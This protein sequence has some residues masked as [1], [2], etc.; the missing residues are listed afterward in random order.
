MAVKER[1]RNSG[2]SM[3]KMVRDPH[4]TRFS[5]LGLQSR[6]AELRCSHL[7]LSANFFLMRLHA[8]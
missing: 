6:W 4:V 1:S 7:K 2:Q 5:A 8:Q 3:L